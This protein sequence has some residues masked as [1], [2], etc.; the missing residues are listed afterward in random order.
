MTTAERH[1]MEPNLFPLAP[2]HLRP[3]KAAAMKAFGNFE[4]LCD[5]TCS[6]ELSAPRAPRYEDR[7]TTGPGVH[8]SLGAGHGDLGST[9]G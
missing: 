4:V 8:E 2:R 6:H 9:R 7:L 5:W 1:V 3:Q